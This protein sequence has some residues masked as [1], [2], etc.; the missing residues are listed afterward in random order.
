MLSARNL[1]V[2]FGACLISGIAF[3]QAQPAPLA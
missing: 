1:V 3:A 2:L